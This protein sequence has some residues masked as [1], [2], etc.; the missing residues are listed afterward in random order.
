MRYKCKYCEEGYVKK[1]GVYTPCK[2]CITPDRFQV[3]LEK[4]IANCADSMKKKALIKI[5]ENL[6]EYPVV[7]LMEA[8]HYGKFSK[9]FISTLKQAYDIKPFMDVV[10]KPISN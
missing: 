9:E 2:H 6:P 5:K 1:N 10:Y 8:E 3:T 4:A 7:A